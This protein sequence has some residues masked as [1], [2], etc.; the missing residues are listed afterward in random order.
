MKGNNA[1]RRKFL[2]TACIGS[3]GAA[4]AVSSQA[5]SA[6]AILSGKKRIMVGTFSDETNTFIPRRRTLEQTKR[7][8]RYGKDAIGG[9]GFVD[10]CKMYDVELIGSIRAGGDH[11]LMDADVFDYVTG[12]MLDTLDKNQVDGIYMNLHGGG[13]TEGHDD[14][15]G[16]TLALLREKVGP[17]IPISF[18]LDM[19]CDL[20]QLEAQSADMVSIGFHYPQYDRFEYA[21][22]AGWLLMGALFGKIKPVIAIKKLPLMIGPPLNVRTASYPIRLVYERSLEIQRTVPG[23][24][25][26]NPAH[27][28]MQQDIPTQGVGVAV[29]ADRDRDLAQ[30]YADEV[31][32]LF[33]SFR[34]EYWVDLPQPEEAIKRALKIERPVAIADG[35]DNM[36]AGGAGDGAHFLREILR[37]NVK[38]AIVQIYDREAA[39]KAAEKG[40]GSTVTLDVGGKSDPLYGPP[41]SVTGKVIQVKWN[42]R[43]TNP[44]VQLEVNGMTLVLNPPS[45]DLRQMGIYPEKYKMTVNKVGHEHG[46]SYPPD[47]FEIMAAD[48]PGWTTAIL[49]SFTWKR[50]PRPM[51][52]LD[53]I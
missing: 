49:D 4:S 45:R 18:S 44:A 22:A 23:I 40:K 43:K 13:N 11:S 39:Q 21:Q 10:A 7:S 38:S 12:V 31:G 33:F 19:H 16:E 6:P 36:G 50:I 35:G 51:Y 53:D 1:N 37:Q 14:L 28:F 27:G 20:T 25:G 47:V 24:L 52:P 26:V 41:V 42:E 15:E 2:K 32:D 48:A 5:I 17:D 9:G 3:L 30:K 29:T 34:K 46:K 8:A